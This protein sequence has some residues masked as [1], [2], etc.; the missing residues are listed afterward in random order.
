MKNA[1]Y[2]YFKIPKDDLEQC[3]AMALWK[4]LQDKQ[5]GKIK[6]QFSTYLCNRVKWECVRYIIESKKYKDL[7]LISEI[8]FYLYDDT[9]IT[10][11]DSLTQEET[12]IIEKRFVQKM[13]L[14]E[15]GKLYGVCAE[16]ARQRIKEIIEKLQDEWS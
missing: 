4:T 15:I 14:K 3:K 6:H 2:K 5:A 9:V 11:F 10:V 8:G 13:T 16:R 12:S 1:S 7:Q